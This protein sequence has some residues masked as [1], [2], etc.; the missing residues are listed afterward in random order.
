MVTHNHVD[1]SSLFLDHI[2][3][4]AILTFHNIYTKW[5]LG[6]SSRCF[7]LSSRTTLLAIINTGEIKQALSV[8]MHENSLSAEFLQ[9]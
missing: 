5:V 1:N 4:L 8:V 7:L 9:T 6:H 3:S 2:E